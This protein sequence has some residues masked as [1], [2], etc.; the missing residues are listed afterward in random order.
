M[1]VYFSQ[2]Y[3]KRL[4]RK[5][6]MDVKSAA[7]CKN[8]NQLINYENLLQLFRD[9][10]LSEMYYIKNIITKSRKMLRTDQG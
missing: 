6:I 3:F 5:N 8:K 7:S 9:S 10:I 1:T 2:E 4:N